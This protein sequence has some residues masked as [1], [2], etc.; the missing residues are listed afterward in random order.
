MSAPETNAVLITGGAQGI[1]KALVG[2]FLQQGFS[3]LLVDNDEEAG[4]ETAAEYGGLGPVHFCAADVGRPES[5]AMAVNEALDRFG[6][7]QVLI[8]NAG[9]FSPR[10]ME[11]VAPE[12]WLRTIAVNLNAAFFFSRQAAPHLRGK[13]GAIIN[14]A[15][16]RAHMSEPHTE[17]YSASKGGLLALT[18]A[19]AISLGPEV[20][21][22][23]I[24]PGW[25]D[26]RGW[27]KRSARVSVPLSEQDHRQHPA[28]RVGKPE[29]V[30]RLAL[31]L[32]GPDASFITGQEF[33]VD[34]GMTR[35]MI[36]V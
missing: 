32:C 6:G 20:R 24:S 34:G 3:V 5:A 1:G 23:C 2:A 14:I 19:M 26:V 16:T 18:H 36:Y 25:I 33:V 9:L 31:W 7:L 27:K 29:D 22:N 13:G 28:G 11:Q 10:P 30:A 35:K 8:N 21:V 4:R 17:A 15:S 12:E